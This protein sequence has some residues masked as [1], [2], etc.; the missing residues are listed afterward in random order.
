MRDAEGICERSNAV[1]KR[2]IVLI[3]ICSAF[4]LVQSAVPESKSE[5][6]SIWFTEHVLNPIL[7]KFGI[8]ADKDIV[9]KVAHVV[10]F[11]VL[12]VIISLWW[13]KPMK[14]FYAGFTLAFLD[15]SLQVVTGRG[16]LIT[17]IWIDLIGV[18][19]GIGISLVLL[20][21][22]RKSVIKGKGG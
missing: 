22:I 9:R 8:V 19:I 16:A 14:T 20:S 12:A 21:L 15:E 3:A 6:E 4:I 2:W 13:K 11:C 5:N 7:S 10:E 18:A 17:D 1:K